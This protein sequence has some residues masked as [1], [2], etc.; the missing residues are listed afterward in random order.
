MQTALIL[1]RLGEAVELVDG[2]ITGIFCIPFVAIGIQ[3]CGNRGGGN[4]QTISDTM[5]PQGN[6][7]ISKT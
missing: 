5:Q 6:L 7:N 1:N 3:N 4:M 2:F